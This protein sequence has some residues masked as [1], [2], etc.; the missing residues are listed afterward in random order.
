MMGLLSRQSHFYA[1]LEHC[2]ERFDIFEAWTTAKMKEG[3]SEPVVQN[4]PCTIYTRTS[5]EDKAKT[6]NIQQRVFASGHPPDY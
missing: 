3:Y 4:L 6:K 2:N 1:T 5:V